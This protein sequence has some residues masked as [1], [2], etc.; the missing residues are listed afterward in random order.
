MG[1]NNKPHN[2]K[3]FPTS[4]N[5]THPQ[6]AAARYGGLTMRDYFAAKIMAAYC[7]N[8]GMMENATPGDKAV[9]AYNA[10][11]AMLIERGA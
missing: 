4:P 3:A 1:M 8:P 9:M 6:W 11:D 7:S 5:D 2:P 10:A